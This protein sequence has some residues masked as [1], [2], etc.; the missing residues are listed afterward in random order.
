[1]LILDLEEIAVV[2]AKA[3]ERAAVSADLDVDL[4]LRHLPELQLE[5]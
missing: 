2:C 1:M 3:A 5:T 4:L